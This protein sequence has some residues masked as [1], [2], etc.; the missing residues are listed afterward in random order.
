MTVDFEYEVPEVIWRPILVDGNATGYKVDPPFD[1]EWDAL[2]TLRHFAALIEHRTGMKVRVSPTAEDGEC[3]E[4]LTDHV[5]GGPASYEVM[6]A[7][8][9]GF[10]SGHNSLLWKAAKGVQAVTEVVEESTDSSEPIES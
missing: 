1:W 5:T 3:Y 8:M 6:W 2:T 7:W 10:E 4:V 9:S